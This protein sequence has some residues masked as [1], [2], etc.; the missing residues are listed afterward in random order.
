MYLLW[1]QPR[2]QMSCLCQVAS[3]KD[4]MFCGESPLE[5]P[6][7]PPTLGSD[8][9]PWH[10]SICPFLL[11][12]YL[13]WAALFYSIWSPLQQRKWNST[14]CLPPCHRVSDWHKAT[15]NIEGYTLYYLIIHARQ[16]SSS[17]SQIPLAILDLNPYWS[18]LISNFIAQRNQR[19]RSH[20]PP[21]IWESGPI[22]SNWFEEFF[23]LPTP[24]GRGKIV[25]FE[26]P[27]ILHDN[28]QSTKSALIA[29]LP[30]P[31]E[32]AEPVDPEFSM[33]AL[34]TIF[35]V[36]HCCVV[37]ERCIYFVN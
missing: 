24:Q 37:I 33:E 28:R 30:S 25:C 15:E 23:A 19:S 2:I 18:L 14:V 35:M 29:R 12:R 34:Y 31:T 5:G 7:Y 13:D 32:T 4:F 11:N 16:I 3:P 36:P 1:A 6:L 22:L 20:C 27:P 17:W 9:D 10:S 21:T 26:A 8:L